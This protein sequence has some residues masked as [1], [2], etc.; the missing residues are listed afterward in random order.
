MLAIAPRD[1]F[2]EKLVELGCIY[3]ELPMSQSGV[4]PFADLLLAWRLLNI[5]RK[6]KP[7]VVLGYT[8][9]P[10]IYGALVSR[11]AGI[12]IICNVSGLG[13]VFLWNGLASQLARLLYRVA[14][15]FSTFI[16]F[17]NDEDQALFIEQIGVTVEKTAVLPG[18]GIDLK[19]FSLQAY[20]PSG[21]VT[22]LMIA[23]LLIEKGVEEFVN[24]AAIVKE[25]WPNVNFLLVGA[26]DE[27]HKRS[28]SQGQLDS[29]VA[30]GLVEYH[31]PLA[32]I[33]PMIHAC[34]V[35]V[36]PSYREGTPRTLLEGGAIGRAL[37]ATDVPGCRHV[38]NDGENGF[39]CQPQS[40]ED[41]AQKMVS[42]LSL[43]ADEK[44]SM[45]LN[46]HRIIKE[47]Y[48]QKLVIDQYA[49]RI[50]ALH[51]LTNQDQIS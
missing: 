4:N 33:R 27:A 29:W 3:R 10:N 30:S 9:K 40:S 32:D 49:N 8:I 25:K 7:D 46:S 47:K 44:I 23:R 11:I 51:A 39:L 17:Q 31:S 18:S 1:D 2:S 5:L 21:Q 16:F 22:F 38:V 35:V 34:D 41:L 50:Q 36:L 14:F 6:E 19:H 28:I 24:A 42:Y 45:A 12:P 15:R 37:I 26:L 43:T 13:T 20:C 48:D